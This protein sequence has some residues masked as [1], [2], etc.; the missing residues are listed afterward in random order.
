MPDLSNK[1]TRIRAA[2]VKKVIGIV[3][4]SSL[5]TAGFLPLLH[6]ADTTASAEKLFVEVFGLR[7]VKNMPDAH[8]IRVVARDTPWPAAAEALKDR[9]KYVHWNQLT[10]AWQIEYLNDP[11]LIG[12]SEEGGSVTCSLFT[13]TGK[14]EY[15]VQ[16]L[17]RNYAL[18]AAIL[19]EKK[20]PGQTLRWNTALA[21]GKA[22]ITYFRETLETPGGVLAITMKP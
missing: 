14:M 15:I 17:K 12:L 1:D 16:E 22:V 10:E 20:T 18:D 3:L 5:M 7:C 2:R 9:I 11:Y 13:G 19:D 21:A 4:L 6:A 8:K